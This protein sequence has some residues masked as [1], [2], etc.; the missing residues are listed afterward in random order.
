MTGI[1]MTVELGSVLIGLN[2]SLIMV[3]V[4][5][6][7]HAWMTERRFSTLEG[8][9]SLNRDGNGDRPLPHQ[10]YRNDG[11]PVTRTLSPRGRVTRRE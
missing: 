4:V 7:G 11:G 9:R 6:V 3:A 2:V 10:G 1:D 5:L 8:F